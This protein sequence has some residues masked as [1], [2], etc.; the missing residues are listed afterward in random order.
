[1]AEQKRLMRREMR[2]K[3]F[4]IGAEIRIAAST[5]IVGRIT[6]SLAWREAGSVALFSPLASEPD[7]S[8]LL[9]AALMVGK[10]VMYPRM[11]GGEL[12]LC[13]VHSRGDFQAGAFGILE[14]HGESSPLAADLILVPGLAFDANG[15]RLGRGKGYYDRLLA[16]MTKARTMGVFFSCQQAQRIPAEG[17]D[18][19][20]DCVATEERLDV[21]ARP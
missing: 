7:I 5:G 13:V 1:M 11:K 14:P 21:F 20:L 17:H 6:S 15:H 19:R 16:L 2:E 12:E 8:S 4:A 10:D 3:L 18:V 9:D